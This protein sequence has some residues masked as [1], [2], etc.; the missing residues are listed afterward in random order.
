MGE[1]LKTAAYIL[2]KVPSK[3]VSKTPYELWTG[4]KPSLAHLRVWGCAAEARTYN[5]QSKKLDPRTVSCFLLDILKNQE[6][7]DFIVLLIP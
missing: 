2:N 4:K 5:P 7:I 3:F 6:V 1:A